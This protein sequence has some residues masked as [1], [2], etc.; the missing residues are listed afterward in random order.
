MP[1]LASLTSQ[2]LTGLGITRGV[3]PIFTLD[4]PNAFDTSAN[5]WFGFPVDI[6]GNLIIIGA[7]QEDDAGGLTSGKAYIYNATTGALVH[8]LD[9]PNGYD[10]S[11]NDRFGYSVS[12]SGN[13]AIVGAYLE[14]DAGGSASGKAYIFNATTGALVHTLDNPNAFD[15]SAVDIFGYSVAISG[16]YAIVGAYQEDD[17]L[18]ANSGK[19][20]IFDV[21]TGLLVHTLDNPNALA[22]A[23]SDWFGRTLDISGDRC[24]VSAYGETN[25]AGESGSGKAY[26]FNVTT[27]ELVDTL[28]NPDPFGTDDINDYF[29]WSVAISGNRAIV[30]CINED[31]ADNTN[32]GK[33]Y[34]F[35]VTT[36]ALLHTLDNPN[37]FGTSQGDNFGGS[38]AIS[39]NYAIV[40]AASEDDAGGTT[41]GK[42]YIFDV[43]TGLLVHT[44]DNPNAF[45]T[46]AGDN[47]G[48]MVSISGDRCIVSAYLE[49]DG[50]NA[51]GTA[52]IYKLPI[53]RPEAALLYTLDNP[54]AFDT[55]DSD[56]FGTSVAIS[57]NRAIVGATRE[58]EGGTSS[59]KAYIF[60]ATTGSLVHTLDNPNA[61]T[62]D[63]F[64]HS[65][66]ISGN[67]AIVGALYEDDPG[68]FNSG[69][70]YIFDVT[71]GALVYT[72]DNPNAYGTALSDFFGWS[73][74]ISGNYAIV[75]AYG[76]DDAD[77]TPSGKAYIFDVTTGS[78]VHTLDNPNAYNT[79]VGDRFGNSVS[80]S[81]NYAI[82]G[83]WLEGDASGNQSGKA[84]IFDAT[85]GSLV[86]TLD[87]PN[88]F[89]TSEEDGFGHSVS[90][91]GNYA[92]V[93]ARFEDDAGGTSSG[94]AYIYN[95]ISGTL[96]HTLDNPNAFD[97][98]ASDLFGISVA[99]S[100][101]YTIVGA[102]WED[103]AGGDQ[104]GKA[105]IYEFPID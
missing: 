99:I 8:T 45:G 75:G 41:S 33:A 102:L 1:R 42:A 77:G 37:A 46:S 47:F 38:V 71:T 36:G 43:T 10:T 15:T 57:G 55:S 60:D 101:N 84:Y 35:N 12:M 65:V 72:L 9:N 13:R 51:S 50:G 91:S 82:V 39:G 59:G 62:G 14:D 86:H 105:Y 48:R 28:D 29:G 103:D 4:N 88:A 64:G 31:D 27:G 69:K 5:D 22:P 96:V 11:A 24:I 58:D 80:I 73:V 17:F 66:A 2:A 40:G 19:A 53:A 7:Y 81:G 6:D 100:G 93:S 32:S 67:R 83:A 54:N 20:Y 79:S 25:E 68:N 76:E 70:A 52:Y 85:T 18:G 90:I 74:S 30:S 92:I 16:N 63:E 3:S 104:S 98:S 87:N 95:V 61:S 23:A 78:L 21:T 56:Q 44:V 94:K 34:I 97:T 49:D 89:G 26:I